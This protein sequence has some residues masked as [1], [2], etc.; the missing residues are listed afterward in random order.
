MQ[1]TLSSLALPDWFD[2]FRPHQITAIEEI[3]DA[4]RSGASAVV[5]DAPTGSGKTLIAESVRQLLR[6]GTGNSLSGT[7]AGRG[8]SADSGA[9][10]YGVPSYRTVYVC[11]TKS[12]QSQ[13][14]HDY[15]HAR[16]LKGRANYATE[17]YPEKFGTSWDSLSCEDCTK[18]L[19]AD[20]ACKFCCDVSSCPYECAKNEALSA[21]LAVL[22]T[23]YFLTESNYIG[24]FSG[25]DFVIA[26]ECDLLDDAVTG[27]VTVSISARRVKE[28]GIS[29]PRYI[30]KEDSWREWAES[31]T[32]R[33]REAA[34][35][36]RDKA[37][38]SSSPRDVK[39]A[40]TLS[41]LARRMSEL[42]HGLEAGGWV[43]TGT[44]ER[45]EFQPVWADQVAKEALWSHGKKWLL[46]SATVI[47]A[48]SLLSSLGLEPGV[49]WATVQVESTF[50]VENRPIYVRP[51]ANMKATEREEE[52]PKLL[53]AITQIAREHAGERILVHTVSY[54]LTE[55][56]MGN[57]TGL[58]RP[59]WS[60]ADSASRDFALRSYLATPNSILFAPSLDRGVDLPGDACRVQVVAKVPFGNLGDKKISARLYG[61]GARGQLDYTVNAVRTLVQMSG[62]GVR[63][64]TDTCTT[65]ILDRQFEWKLYG[66]NRHLFP[67]WWR[68]A[69]KWRA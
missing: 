23:S 15:P 55:Y 65:Y 3:L 4:Y 68:N 19:S 54:A 31:A 32:P 63:S 1:S 43:Y 6:N 28:L 42:N 9:N 8:A 7:L 52:W 50:P 61:S 62:R 58:L 69:L 47:N 37:R 34:C 22:N 39:M 60:Y 57:L 20:G 35:L 18:Q 12:L 59:K 13:F 66:S 21:D 30:T 24:R 10:R 49:N 2:T 25:R 36:S 56:L 17:L 51:V 26:D 27:F 5:L 14:I 33:V 41:N 16:L 48:E 64:E 45:V 29:T 40:N 46:M 53:P 44:R 11:S 67:K 38:H